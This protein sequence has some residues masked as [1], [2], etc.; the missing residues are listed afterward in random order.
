M[1]LVKGFGT[2][3]SKKGVSPFKIIVEPPFSETVF[4]Q[5]RYIL[6]NDQWGKQGGLE[7]PDFLSTFLAYPRVNDA[8]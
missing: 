4:V 5:Q 7:F 8:V 6:Q 1:V 2:F 3:W